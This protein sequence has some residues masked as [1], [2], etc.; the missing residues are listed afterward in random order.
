MARWWAS[1]LNSFYSFPLLS[2]RSRLF[3]IFFFYFVCATQSPSLAMCVSNMCD[4]RLSVSSHLML[5]T[6]GFRCDWC[7]CLVCAHGFSVPSMITSFSSFHVSWLVGWTHYQARNIHRFYE[8]FPLRSE[9]TSVSL[10]MSCDYVL[11]VRYARAQS[12][13]LIRKPRVSLWAELIYCETYF[14]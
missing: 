6:L 3:S 10:H 14:N 2:S 11:S 1:R 7:E 9:E 5:P 12:Y 13:I 8:W 4:R